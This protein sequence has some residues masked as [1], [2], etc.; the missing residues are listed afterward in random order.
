MSWR[1]RIDLDW[2]S[3][4]AALTPSP[5]RFPSDIDPAQAEDIAALLDSG[6][7]VDSWV[8]EAFAKAEAKRPSTGGG[9]K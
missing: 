6:R 7:P 9:K 8:A 3:P 5:T 4:L 1:P 2:C